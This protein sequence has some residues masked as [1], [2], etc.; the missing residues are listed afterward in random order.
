MENFK[1]NHKHNK[2][3]QRKNTKRILLT[4]EPS[5]T[6]SDDIP[7]IFTKRKA[8]KTPLKKMRIYSTRS[9]RR[10]KKPKK[11]SLYLYRKSQH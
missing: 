5:T 7:S 6:G 10:F 3:I 8:N 4:A 11:R 2:E 9:R 1:E